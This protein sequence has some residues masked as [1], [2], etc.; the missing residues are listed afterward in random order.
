MGMAHENTGRLQRPTP[1][2][3]DILFS[4][5]VDTALLKNQKPTYGDPHPLSG[6]WP[7][8]K[9]VFCEPIAD[10]KKER[11]YY[12]ADR[13]SQ[14]LY[15]WEIGPGE[16]VTRTYFIPRDKYF[17]RPVD[18]VSAVEGEFLFPPPG[19]ASPDIRFAQY[20]FADDSIAEAPPELRSL[21][22]VIQRRFLRPVTV[23]ISWDES[24]EKYVRTTKEIVPRT[25]ATP[26]VELD[27]KRTEIQDGNYFHSIK[28]TK[29]IILGEAVTYP[30]EISAIPGSQNVNFPPKMES[31]ELWWAFASAASPDGAPSYSEQYFHKFEL[32]EARPGPYSATI[33]RWVTDNPVAF[34][35]SNSLDVIPNP[36]RESIGVSS[37]WAYAGELGNKTQAVAREIVLPASIHDAISIPLNGTV[38]AG[39]T[40][41]GKERVSSLPATPGYSDFVGKST[42][43][44]DYRVRQM[45]L[46]LYEVSLVT[47]DI[48]NLYPSPPPL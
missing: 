46:G 44:L 5:I 42:F 24:F 32:I 1:L 10:N 31:V 27:G 23:D 6:R 11:W 47:I 16:Q 18:H 19:V 22:V 8:H 15:N 45:P 2:I 40:G 35:T 12:A 20:C 28:I 33:Q 30:Y 14:D 7:N 39:P 26:A 9:L 37:W 34:L 21:Y 41:I 4:E 13:D 38:D 17:Q 43:K 48:A 29:E 3:G 36:V 25:T